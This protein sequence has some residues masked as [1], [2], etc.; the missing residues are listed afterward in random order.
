M[1]RKIH[2][3]KKVIFKLLA[4]AVL[5]GAAIVFDLSHDDIKIHDQE[6]K[7]T[8]EQ[9]AHELDQICF[10]STFNSFKLK[11]HSERF[12]VG[13]LFLRTELEFLQ[14]YHHQKAGLMAKL[15]SQK[16][17]PAADLKV[18]LVGVLKCLY[19]NPGDNPLPVL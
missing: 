14:K 5:L 17:N 7:N 3:S 16:I 19:R 9:S 15:E 2:I 4:F 18:H 1:R 6:T 13:R 11:N 12:S 8:R 10:Y